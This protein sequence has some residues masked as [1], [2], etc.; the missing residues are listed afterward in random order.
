MASIA[1][2]LGTAT[3]APPPGALRAVPHSIV[4]LETAVYACEHVL[5]LRCVPAAGEEER[6]LLSLLL[7]FRDGDRLEREAARKFT[8]PRLFGD[9]IGARLE[10]MGR[11]DFFAALAGRES[12]APWALPAARRGD[13]LTDTMVRALEERGLRAEGVL[14]GQS[15][16]SDEAAVRLTPGVLNTEPAPMSV[17][18]NELPA[19]LVCSQRGNGVSGGGTRLLPLE[20]PGEGACF[21]LRCALPLFVKAALWASRA[22]A[23]TA[24]LPVYEESR[25][26]FCGGAAE[27]IL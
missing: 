22:A 12:L 15:S 17:R 11:S 18:L 24:E 20:G 23:R 26:I 19:A 25:T 2:L 14:V 1:I 27:A 4:R 5:S 10:L 8:P 3:I 6:P 9:G 7:G 13:D 16:L 21:A